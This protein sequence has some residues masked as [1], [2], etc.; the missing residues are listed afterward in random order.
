MCA[1]LRSA[2]HYERDLREKNR[3]NRIMFDRENAEEMRRQLEY[4]SAVLVQKRWR[5]NVGRKFGLRVLKEG[6]SKIREA[7][8]LRKEDEKKKRGAAYKIRESMAL[9]KRFSSDSM[10]EAVLRR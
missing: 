9:T 1:S 4:N 3:Q 7:W 6:R 8:R 5:G 2:Q 10:E